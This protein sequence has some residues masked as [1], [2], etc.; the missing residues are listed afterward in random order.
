[1]TSFAHLQEKF[2]AI[3]AAQSD[4]AFSLF[5]TNTTY[6]KKIASVKAPDEALRLTSDHLKISYES[7]VTESQKIA[8]IYKALVP[9]ALQ[10]IADGSSIARP[11]S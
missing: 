6:V 5:E 7:F 10:T 9:T 8:E 4:Y 11:A 3:V 2:A 1:M